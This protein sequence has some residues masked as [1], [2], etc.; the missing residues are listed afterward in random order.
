MRAMLLALVAMP[1]VAATHAVAASS[2][3]Q[4]GIRIV[5]TPGA[6]KAA[7]ANRAAKTRAKLPRYTCAAARNAIVRAGYAVA[8][9]LACRGQAYLFRVR[10]VNGPATI[11]FAPRGGHLSLSR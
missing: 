3:L 6:S 8:A 7:A 4:V 2:T 1:A 5:A 11:T 10:T 9:T